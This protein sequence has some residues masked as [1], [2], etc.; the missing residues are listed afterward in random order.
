MDELDE[1]ITRYRGVV[2][3]IADRERELNACRLA[4]ATATPGF[5]RHDVLT[6][7]EAQL[8]LWKEKRERLQLAIDRNRAGRLRNSPSCAPAKY[9]AVR[10]ASS[11]RR[12]R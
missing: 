4:V 9:P 11:P 7:L 10:S 3:E 6:F 12:I 1:L 8:R 2:T 5:P